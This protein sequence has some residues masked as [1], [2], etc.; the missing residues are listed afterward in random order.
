MQARRN[1]SRSPFHH[2]PVRLRAPRNG[3]VR[4]LAFAIG[5][6]ALAA[7]PATRA[8]DAPAKS[9]TAHGTEVHA[10][11]YSSPPRGFVAV[12]FLNRTTLLAQPIVTFNYAD[13]PPQSWYNAIAPGCWES[14]VA[15]CGVLEIE[16]VGVV[17]I[18]LA[19]NIAGSQVSYTGGK[20]V[21]NE[22]FVCGS[23][24]VVRLDTDP[25][26]S[27]SLRISVSTIPTPTEISDKPETSPTAPGPTSKLLLVLPQGV[28]GA[29]ANGTVSWERDNGHVYLT[30]W[31]LRGVAPRIGSLAEC[32]VVRVG[33]GDLLNSQTPGVVVNDQQSI[34]APAP[35]SAANGLCG[36]VI[37]LGIS[38]DAANPA[39]LTLTASSS[40]TGAEVAAGQIDLF[41]NIRK[42]LDQENF[43][44]K[45]SGTNVLEVPFPRRP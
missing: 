34:A 24:V 39:S 8:G 31:E 17:P 44:G 11:D 4:R 30:H 13:Q 12:V 6:L 10:P 40:A 32:P 14:F 3:A 28:S 38:G 29:K 20:L 41:G 33:W 27:R 9:A 37:R 42:L 2:C 21:A 15:E 19:T 43:T 35:L 22:D 26:A 25:A 18:E 5:F 7:A 1:P 45:L 16:L 23:I 36:E